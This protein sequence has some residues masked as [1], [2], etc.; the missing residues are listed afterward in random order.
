ML[1]KNYFSSIY[2]QPKGILISI[3]L[4][5]PKN[6]SF[7]KVIGKLVNFLIGLENY[8]SNKFSSKLS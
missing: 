8:N 2:S 5:Q 1:Q 6:T 7:S 3:L 4:I